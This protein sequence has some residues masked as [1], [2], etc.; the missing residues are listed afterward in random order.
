[1]CSYCGRRDGRKPLNVRTWQCPACS[2]TLDRDYNAAVN[3]LDAAGLAESL[4]ARGDEVRRALASADEAHLSTKR[5][6]TEP[7]ASI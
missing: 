2:T 6:P 3:I 1:M 5:E 4:N 7:H